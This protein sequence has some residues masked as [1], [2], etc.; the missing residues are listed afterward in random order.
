MDSCGAYFQDSVKMNKT[1]SVVSKYCAEHM[2]A[3]PKF[4]GHNMGLVTDDEAHVQEHVANVQE[5]VANVQEHVTNVQENVA[6]VQEHVANVQEEQVGSRYELIMFLKRT[7][8]RSTNARRTR[9]E[10][11]PCV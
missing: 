5:H 1:L 10:N 9:Q 6:N 2:M 8:P 11:T 7:V 3:V 4:L